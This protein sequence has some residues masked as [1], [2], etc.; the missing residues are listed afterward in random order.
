VIGY[1]RH[2]QA[3]RNWATAVQTYRTALVAYRRLVEA[4]TQRATGNGLPL[5]LTR[6]PQEPRLASPER[7]EVLTPREREVACLLARGYTNQ[8][9][10]NELVLT[11]GTVANHVAHILEKLG[12]G[13]R[14]QVAARVL[15]RADELTS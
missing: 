12:V 3:Q 2:D 9:I 6:V 7:L 10:A 5:F 13:N 11:R 4:R 15:G 8:Q 1:E 14:T